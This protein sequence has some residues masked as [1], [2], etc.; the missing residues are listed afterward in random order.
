LK[1]ALGSR[2]LDL[3]NVRTS[4]S[5][6]AAIIQRCIL[7]VSEDGG[8][9][10]VS[11]VLGVPTVGLFGATRWVWARPH[12][13]HS[14][15]ILACTLPDGVCMHGTCN[16]GSGQSCLTDVAASTVVDAAFRLL[17]RIRQQPRVIQSAVARQCP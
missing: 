5:E 10:H 14:E 13:S 17:D 9:M 2:L 1:A 16:R 15:L 12:G 6:A 11:W 3:V 8:L 7:A 4:L